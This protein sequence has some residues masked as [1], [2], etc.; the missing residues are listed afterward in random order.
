MKITNLENCEKLEVCMEGAK[1]A[2]RQ[3]PISKN[4]GSPTCSVRVF[5][6]EANGHTPFHTHP[7]EHVNYVIEG[8]GAIVSEDGAEREFKKGDFA[9]IMP[10]EKHQYKNKSANKPFVFICAV[11]KEYE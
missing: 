10:D 1:N 2:F 3:T 4:D 5:T 11:P 9:F 7:F 6:L 8:Q